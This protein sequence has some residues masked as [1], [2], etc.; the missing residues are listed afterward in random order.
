MVIVVFGLA[1]A[2]GGLLL[3]PAPGPGWIITFLGLGLLG[4]EFN[5]MARALD[6]VELKVRAIAG[7]AKGVWE[8]SSPVLKVLIVLIGVCGIAALGYGAYQLVASG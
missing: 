8:R 6:W 7:W 5:P 3:V 4:S 2:L 1:I